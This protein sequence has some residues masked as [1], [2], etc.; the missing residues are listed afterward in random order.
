MKDLIDFSNCEF[1]HR[2][3][4]GSEKK[5]GIIYKS[6]Y[7]IIKFQKT[8]EFGLRYN[9]ISEYIGSHVFNMAWY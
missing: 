3:Y 7:Y 1:S 8:N 6:E 4:G 9:H 2:F 5:Y